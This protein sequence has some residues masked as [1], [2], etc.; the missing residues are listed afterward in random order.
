MSEK[1]KRY[2][3]QHWTL[4]EGWVANGTI[5]D[6]NGE[7]YPASYDTFEEAIGEVLYFFSEI[8]SQ[9]ASGERDPEDGYDASEFRVLDTMTGRATGFMQKDGYLLVDFD[10]ADQ[11]N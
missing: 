2:I 8:H 6:E 3:E 5:T 7:E 9:I 11:A 4:C 10:S 1:T